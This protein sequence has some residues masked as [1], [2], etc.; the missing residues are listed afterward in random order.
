MNRY[1]VVILLFSC[2]IITCGQNEHSLNVSHLDKKLQ[3]H[4]FDIVN[5]LHKPFIDLVKIHQT[6]HPGGPGDWYANKQ[7]PGQTFYEYKQRK[8]NEAW[9]TIYIQ[10]IGQFSPE[11]EKIVTLVTRYIGAFFQ[12]PVKFTKPIPLEKISP[13]ARRVHPSWGDKQIHT[14]YILRKILRP[15]RPKDAIAYIA[16][17]SY[18]LYPRASWNFV[19]GQASLVNRVGVFSMYRNGDPAESKEM[20]RLCFS[21]TAKTATHEIGHMLGIR[22]CIAFDCCMN[23]SNNRSESDKHP[24]WLCPMCLNKVNW[25]LPFNITKRYDELATILESLGLNQQKFLRKSIKLLDGK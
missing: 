21:R 20:F 23:G 2:I 17:T 12:V 25:F 5:E 11:Q 10:K 9:T 4:H 7:E 8:K 14:K 18:D 22:H 15:R 19:Y 16:L 3:K 1:V 6:F 24:L 13:K